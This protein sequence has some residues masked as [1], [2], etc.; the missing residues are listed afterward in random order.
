MDF[1]FLLW[2][3]DT[4][5]KKTGNKTGNKTYVRQKKRRGQVRDGIG[6]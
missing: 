3:N 2:Y 4:D 1:L 6:T 5:E